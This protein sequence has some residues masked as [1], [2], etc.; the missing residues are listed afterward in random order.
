MSTVAEVGTYVERVRAAL[1]DLPPDDREELLEDLRDHLTEVAG[2]DGDG[3]LEALLGPPESY[4]AELRSSAGLPPAPAGSVRDRVAALGERA[5]LRSTAQFLPELLPGWW[6]LRGVLLAW[7]GALWLGAGPAFVLLAVV[8]VVGSVLLGVRARA[9]RDDRR[10]HR[11]DVG[12][13]AAAVAAAVLALFFAA[14]GSTLQPAPVYETGPAPVLDGVT[15]IHPYSSDGRPLTDVLLYDQD[16]RPIVLP[17]D[18]QD[19]GGRAIST[20]PRYGTDGRVVGNVYPREQT[21]TDYAVELD[22]TP[23]V[24]RAPVPTVTPPRLEPR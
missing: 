21:V 18:G 5:W 7:V 2:E 19:A 15:N 6:V 23:T 11:A 12:V 10:L 13:T 24:R 9:D 1:A 20:V 14:A 17:A 22:G 3:S 16:G 4:A 8:A